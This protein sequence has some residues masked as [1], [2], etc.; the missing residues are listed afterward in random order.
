MSVSW[1]PK[2]TTKTMVIVQVTHSAIPNHMILV[3]TKPKSKLNLNVEKYIL[4]QGAALTGRGW[5]WGER[6]GKRSHENIIGRASELKSPAVDSLR[7]VRFDVLLDTSNVFRPKQ[8]NKSNRTF[9]WRSLSLFGKPAFETSKC[10]H[11]TRA[12]SLQASCVP[13]KLVVVELN[14]Q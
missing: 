1:G 8:C 14:K 10:E 2:K 13:R 4:G 6:S 12:V 7:T 9:S 11:S 3:F 5:L